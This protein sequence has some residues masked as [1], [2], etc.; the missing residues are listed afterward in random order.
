MNKLHNNLFIVF[1][2]VGI[3]SGWFNEEN[4]WA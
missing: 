3:V 2:T 1:S 4:G